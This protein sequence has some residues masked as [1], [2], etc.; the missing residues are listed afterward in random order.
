[1]RVA[2]LLTQFEAAQQQDLT[3]ER[4]QMRA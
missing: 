4:R 1:V 2:A 3:R